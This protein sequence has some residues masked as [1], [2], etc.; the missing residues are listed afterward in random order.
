MS[1]IIISINFQ[2]GLSK[3]YKSYISDKGLS[4]EIYRENEIGLFWVQGSGPENRQSV[5]VDLVSSNLYIIA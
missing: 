4:D 5:Q 1:K 2:G 3:G